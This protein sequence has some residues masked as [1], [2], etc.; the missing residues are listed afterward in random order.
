M[1]RRCLTGLSTGRAT[2]SLRRPF[3]LLRRRRCAP[4][5]S[6]VCAV[7]GTNPA[8]CESRYQVSAEPKV[9]RRASASPRGG[10]RRKFK[11]QSRG[12]EQKPDMRRDALGTSGHVTAK[13]SI[14]KP[15]RN[16]GMG[17]F[18]KSGAYARKDSCLTTGDLRGVGVLGRTTTGR[19]ETGAERRAEVSRGHSR[20]GAP[21]RRPERSESRVRG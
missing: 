21:G 2:A 4:V 3:S 7:H 18:C 15:G 13:S 19:R 11:A 10:V 14:C 9:S 1:C 20:P 16:A 12:D 8:G 17:A 5:T 6:D